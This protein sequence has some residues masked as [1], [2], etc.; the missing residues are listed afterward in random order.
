MMDILEQ[1]LKSIITKVKDLENKLQ[2]DDKDH[3]RHNSPPQIYNIEID[4]LDKEHFENKT[5]G[6]DGQS[7][8]EGFGS[9]VIDAYPCRGK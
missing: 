3:R 5:V 4:Q 1:E 6:E 2:R 7:V 8:D 9:Q